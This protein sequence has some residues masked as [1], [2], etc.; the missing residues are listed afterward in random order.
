M[1]AVWAVWHQGTPSSV[2]FIG[3][4]RNQKALES[5]IHHPL[6]NYESPLYKLRKLLHTNQVTKS[7]QSDSKVDLE[8]S[9]KLANMDIRFGQRKDFAIAEMHGEMSEFKLEEAKEGSQLALQCSVEDT[10]SEIP[11]L[12]ECAAIPPVSHWDLA[13]RDLTHERC[14]SQDRIAVE[15]HEDESRQSIQFGA[16]DPRNIF[17]IPNWNQIPISLSEIL[18]FK[19]SNPRFKAHRLNT[20]MSWCY[21]WDWLQ[22]EAWRD[23]ICAFSLDIRQVPREAIPPRILPIILQKP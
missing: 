15:I 13:H 19:G 7:G 5:F 1:I 3:K 10:N 8:L 6:E 23:G 12:D 16:P 2:I 21:E 14:A 11:L 9:S 18:E 22:L 17:P 4:A 20:T